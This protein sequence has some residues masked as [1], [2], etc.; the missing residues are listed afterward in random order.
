MSATRLIDLKK[1]TFDNYK[2]GVPHFVMRD[3]C[4]WLVNVNVNANDSSILFLSFILS[5]KPL[6]IIIIETKNY[7]IRNLKK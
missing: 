1:R 5:Y 7:N 2:L 6:I 4:C 3:S